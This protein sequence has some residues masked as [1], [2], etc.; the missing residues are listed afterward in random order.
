MHTNILG[1]TEE[2]PHGNTHHLGGG[3]RWS[4]QLVKK[5]QGKMCVLKYLVVLSA[6]L[7]HFQC[8]IR[9]VAR[10]Y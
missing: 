4:W 7:Q 8:D 6:V 5:K 10:Y 2:T 3:A 1:M 9:I